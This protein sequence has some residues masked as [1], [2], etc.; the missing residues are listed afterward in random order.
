V[1]T[2]YIATG[3]SFPDGLSAGPA[4]GRNGAPLLLVKPTA[5]PAGVAE[6]LRRLNPT[7]VIVVGGSGVVSDGVLNAILALWP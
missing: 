1:D 6:E 7:T 4:A 5:V 3:T 2:V